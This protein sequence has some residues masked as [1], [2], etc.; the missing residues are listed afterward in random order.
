MGSAGPSGLPQHLQQ[1]Q[2]LGGGNPANGAAIKH[3]LTSVLSQRGPNA[4]PY[5]EG[6]KFT[7]RE[8]IAHTVQEYPG[9]QVRPATF[10]HND[11]RSLSLLQLEGTIPMWYRNVKYNIPL[12]LWLPDLFP[13]TPPLVFVT[14]T[15]DMII[16]PH[17]AHVDSSGSVDIPYLREWVFQKSSLLELVQMLSVMF[18]HQPPLYAKPVNPS[19]ISQSSAGSGQTQSPH[20]PPSRTSSAGI[21]SHVMDFQATNPMHHAGGPGSGLGTGSNQGGP[22]PQPGF[23]RPSPPPPLKRTEDPIEVFKRTAV[24]SLT[25]RLKRDITMYCEGQAAKMDALLSAQQLL[26]QRKEAIKFGSRELRQ[27]KE[28]LEQALQVYHTNADILETW[29]GENDK[30]MESADVDSVFSPVDGLSK[31]LLDCL[32]ADLAIEDALYALD[33]AVQADDMSGRGRAVPVDMYLQRTRALAR[34]QFFHR[35]IAAKVKGSQAQAQVAA[36]AARA[37]YSAYANLRS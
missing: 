4:L 14:P 2:G 5:E 1:Q 7:I 35:A 8:Q 23:A 3:F 11:G 30:P 31:Q 33:K 27:E 29:L 13:R 37:P 19:G 32:A 17:H 24:A 22:G 21:P 12:S 10:T 15:R 36:M 25:E 28:S 16:R 20:T 9:L 6:L 26:V 34:E 18:G